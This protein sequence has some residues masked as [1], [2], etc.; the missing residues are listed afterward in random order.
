MRHATLTYA[1]NVF[2]RSG[3]RERQREGIR[4]GSLP[5][6]CWSSDGVPAGVPVGGAA[7]TAGGGGGG[8][9]GGSNRAGP[10]CKRDRDTHS[11]TLE[12]WGKWGF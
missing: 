6:E 8:G 3:K 10:E 9:G 1:K 5:G 12:S 4:E 2:K 11:N 7:S